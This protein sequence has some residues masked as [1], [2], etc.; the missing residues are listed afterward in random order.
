MAA[1]KA[2]GSDGLLR[3]DFPGGWK[4]DKYNAFSMTERTARENEAYT[5]LRKLL[6]WRKGNDIVTKGTLKH[7]VPKNGVYVYE[8]KYGNKS[9][10]VFLNGTDKQQTLDLSSYKEVLPSITAIDFAGKEVHLDKSLTLK[11]RETLILTF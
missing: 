3:A 5:Y 4:R 9:V 11:E 10:V 7:F 6:Q 8:R 2:N 1:D